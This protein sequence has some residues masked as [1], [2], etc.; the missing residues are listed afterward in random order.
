MRYGL[1][2]L[3]MSFSAFVW[4]QNKGII[5][6]IVIDNNTEEPLAFAKV[7][8]EGTQFGTDTDLDGTY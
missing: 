8:I 7:F 3:F 2:I 5:S 4:A 6:G 1:L